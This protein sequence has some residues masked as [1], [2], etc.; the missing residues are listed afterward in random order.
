MGAASGETGGSLP[1]T[2]GQNLALFGIAAVIL[3]GAGAVLL[4]LRRRRANG[5]GEEVPGEANAE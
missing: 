4:I 5:T 2:G 1:V 3:L